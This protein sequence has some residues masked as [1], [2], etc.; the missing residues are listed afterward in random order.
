[1]CLYLRIFG[2]GMLIYLVPLFGLHFL[3]ARFIGKQKVFFGIVS[4]SSLLFISI[5]SLIS[6]DVAAQIDL[7]N[8]GVFFYSMLRIVIIVYML[9]QGFKQYN[10][11]VN[12]EKKLFI[13]AIITTVLII[14]PIMF[15][16]SLIKFFHF[17][18][19][20]LS[21]FQLS[22]FYLVWNIVSLSFTA[23][24]FYRRVDKVNIDHIIEIITQQYNITHR[25]KEIISLISEGLSNKAIADT[26]V[27]SLATVKTHIRNIFQKLNIKNRYELLS[28]LKK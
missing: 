21:I 4:L 5:S 9:I 3:G 28:R 10:A 24:Y 20:K 26:L 12:Y 8:K 7:A 6:H 13:K 1:M 19:I 27:I 2:F 25:E 15:I 18:S 14:C 16:G 11:V 22:V 23:W 17:D